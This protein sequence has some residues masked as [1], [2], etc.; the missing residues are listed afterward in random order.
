MFWL[1]EASVFCN[2]VDMRQ[3]HQKNLIVVE[4]L[5]SE[6]IDSLKIRL[7]MRW[8]NEKFNSFS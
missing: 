7:L 3:F 8:K 2:G 1:S 5:G 6:L 4:K